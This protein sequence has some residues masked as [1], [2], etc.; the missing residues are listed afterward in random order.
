MSKPKYVSVYKRM[1][2]DDEFRRRLR[3]AWRDVEWFMG[4]GKALDD[5]AWDK[6]KMQRRIVEDA[7]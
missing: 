7:S 4:G 6:C 3:A 2:T 1:E 5:M